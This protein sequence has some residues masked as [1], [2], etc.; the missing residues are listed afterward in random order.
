MRKAAAFC[1][2]LASVSALAAGILPGGSAAE[3]RGPSG[4][5]LAAAPD[6]V[7]GFTL[8]TYGDLPAPAAAV[9]LDRLPP[10]E[11]AA[12]TIAPA[13]PMP[14]LDKSG[15]APISFSFF[16]GRANGDP[17]SSLHVQYAWRPNFRAMNLGAGIY[18]EIPISKTLRILPYFGVIRSSAT[19][20]PSDLTGNH[21]LYEYRLTVFCVGLPLVV[22]FN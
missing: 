22:R 12:P 11:P 18:K 21:A 15:A 9:S 19:L 6:G 16:L 10:A 2:V 7:P 13:I 1:V 4:F 8:A 14:V 20:R 17:F 5:V 3:H